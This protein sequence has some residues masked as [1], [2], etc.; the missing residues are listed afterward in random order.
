MITKII[1]YDI[2]KIEGGAIADREEP[3]QY[4]VV[5]EILEENEE[6]IILAV[7]KCIS[8]DDLEENRMNIRF[9]I[10]K[11]CI[12]KRYDFQEVENE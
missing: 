7:N 4:Q 1:Y 8:E 2:T 6:F 12:K 10:P 5:G 11:G 9:I 3:L